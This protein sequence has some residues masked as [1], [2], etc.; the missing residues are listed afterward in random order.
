MDIKKKRFLLFFGAVAFIFGAAVLVIKLAQGYRPDFSTKSLRPTGLLVATSIPD[1]AQVFVDGKLKTATNTTINLSPGEYEVEIKK[2]GFFPWK[3]TLQIKKELVT[4]T[5]AYLFANFPDLRALTFTGA[6]NP[7]LSPDGT[8][9]VYAAASPSASLSKQ[10]LWI[11]ELTDRPLGLSREPR[12]IVANTPNYD[13]S[14]ANYRWSPDSKQILVTFK[15]T[16]GKGKTAKIKT[17][18]FLLDSDKFN[19]LTSFQ[20]ITPTLSFLEISWQKEE[21][22]H[23]QTQL[24]KLPKKLLSTLDGRIANLQFAPDETKILYTATASASIPQILTSPPAVV[25][26]Q[27]EEREIKP[28]RIYVYDFKEDKNFFIMEAPAK[29]TVS[30]E[31]A[32]GGR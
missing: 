18:N 32:E 11:L 24:S 23:L 1:G 9:V 10:G 29:S 7:V 15:N 17:E 3:K 30:S 12:Q 16:L 6:Q 25:N 14:K 13:F 19:P 31:A 22:T 8:K 5:D 2:D 20:D 4:K 28:N 26:T 27:K 21:E